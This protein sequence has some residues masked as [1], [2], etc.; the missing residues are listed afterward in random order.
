MGLSPPSAVAFCSSTI[1]P[2]AAV[3]FIASGYRRAA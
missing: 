1:P 2:G 3:I